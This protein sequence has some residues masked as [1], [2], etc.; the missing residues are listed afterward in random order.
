MQISFQKLWSLE[1]SVFSKQELNESVTGA[2]L[3]LLPNEQHKSRFCVPHV[4]KLSHLFSH[5]ILQTLSHALMT[6]KDALKEL[7]GYLR[8]I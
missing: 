3:K 2:D 4:M 8:H 6:T 1:V 7:F 5:H